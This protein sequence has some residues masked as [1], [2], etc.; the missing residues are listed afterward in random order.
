MNHLL[1]QLSEDFILF[2]EKLVLSLPNLPSVI[3]KKWIEFKVLLEKPENLLSIHTFVI[4]L[5][6]EG[7]PIDFLPRKVSLE[8]SFKKTPLDL[9]SSPTKLPE[10]SLSKKEEF[11]LISIGND[12]KVSK[13]KKVNDQKYVMLDDAGRRVEAC[14]NELNGGKKEEVGIRQEE[15]LIREVLQ[16]KEEVGNSKKEAGGGNKKEE[17]EKNKEGGGKN[18]KPGERKEETNRDETGN[19][20]FDFRNEV[21]KKFGEE[22]KERKDNEKIKETP[23]DK[24]NE[25]KEEIKIKF[26][27]GSPEGMDRLEKLKSES[28]KKVTFTPTEESPPYLTPI[29]TKFNPFKIKVRIKMT[30]GHPFI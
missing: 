2:F 30:V 14:K 22:G 25:E 3:A 21:L 28:P 13:V 16:R 27:I 23:A 7:I 5:Y 26:V 1:R 10:K 17:V 4:N 9:L 6:T 24:V 11:G 20:K 18:E 15:V 8:S 29:Q 19:F 12:P